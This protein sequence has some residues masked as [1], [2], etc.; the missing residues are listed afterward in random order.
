MLT[1]LFWRWWQGSCQTFHK[2][3]TALLPPAASTALTATAAA[4]SATLHTS[5]WAAA[6]Y[7]WATL[8]NSEAIRQ[9]HARAKATAEGAPVLDRHRFSRTLL[10]A[11][12]VSEGCSWVEAHGQA[13]AS[14][15]A[16]SGVKRVRVATFP[17]GALPLPLLRA[18]GSLRE[19]RVR[20]ERRA[21][22]ESRER[23]RIPRF[24]EKQWEPL[25]ICR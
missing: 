15:W 24:V 6:A 14:A 22:F 16:A 23:L 2:A 7:S 19:L 5:A 8:H 18:L 21:P 3:N 12:G 11:C 4:A 17:I 1:K 9:T 10:S 20:S 13:H 25:G